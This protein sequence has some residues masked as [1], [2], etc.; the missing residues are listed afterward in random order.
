M[1]FHKMTSRDIRDNLATESYLMTHYEK[2]E[3]LFL[4]YIQKPCI[5]IGKHQNM[6]DEVNLKAARQDKLTLT[7]RLSGGGAVYD[8]LGNI[9]FSFVVDKNK[10]TFGD[11]SSMVEPIVSVLKEMGVQDISVNGRNDI[12]ING[13]KVSGNA[14]YTKKNKMFSHGTLLYD[15]DL[16]KLPAYLNVSEEKLASKHI[17]SVASRVTNIKPYLSKTYQSLS[18]LEFQDELLKRL[19][20]VNDLAD[21]AP[22]EI[23]LDKKDHQEIT[24]LVKDIYGNDDWVFGH[25][26]PFTNKKRAYIPLVGLLE[27]RFQLK[28]GRIHFIDFLG[29]FFNQENLSDLRHHLEDVPYQRIALKKSLEEIEVSHYFTNL[30]NDQ[31]IDFLIGDHSDD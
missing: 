18:T 26:Q 23:V 2:E 13:K 11:Y 28:N 24:Q 15:V 20:K 14:M 3:P 8:D 17:K 5:I 21:I 4:M 9:S 10:A 22:K 29:D 31:L 16:D 19:Y 6:F 27:A 30:T 25:H 7:R 12:L 1:F